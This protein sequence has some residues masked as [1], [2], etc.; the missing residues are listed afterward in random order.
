MLVH[1]AVG[2]VVAVRLRDAGVRGGAAAGVL[3]AARRRAAGR[4]AR[5]RRQRAA[6]P[7]PTIIGMLTALRLLVLDDN[8]LS[9][10]LPTEIGKLANLQVLW[11]QYNQLSGVLPAELAN[12]EKLGR[13]S[14][15]ACSPNRFGCVDAMAPPNRACNAARSRGRRRR[16]PAPGEKGSCYNGT[17]TTPAPSSS[18][19][20]RAAP[21]ARRRLDGGDDGRRARRRLAGR[22]ARGV[23]ARAQLAAAALLQKGGVVEDEQEMEMRAQRE[24]LANLTD[25]NTAEANQLASSASQRTSD[26]TRAERWG[27]RGRKETRTS[28]PN[29]TRRSL[30]RRRASA[31]ADRTS[32]REVSV[33][34]RAESCSCLIISVY[35]FL[36]ATMDICSHITPRA[37][38]A[39]AAGRAPAPPRAS[40]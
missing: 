15:R 22:A 17:W 31:R 29:A 19:P 20:R 40:P 18:R 13:C 4:E 24:Q 35:I 5:P 26:N 9:G 32:L 25:V 33:G 1:G 34:E 3:P 30:S 12:L 10:T 36:L 11:L 37:R 6:R 7:L 38:R 21:A 23:A 2:V 14:R 27:R 28:K 16:A 39:R 8:Q